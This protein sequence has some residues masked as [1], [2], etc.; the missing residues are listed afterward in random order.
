M[1]N[2]S[3]IQLAQDTNVI[4]RYGNNTGSFNFYMAHGGTNF[5]FWQGANAE[6]DGRYEPHIT[7]YDYDGPI[8]ESG[9]T[10]QPGIGIGDGCKFT[11]LREVIEQ[12]TGIEAPEVPPEPKI[13]GYGDVELEAVGTLMDAAGAP[14]VSDLPLHMEEYGQQRGI[15]VYRTELDIA[16][17]ISDDDVDFEKK[18]G[19]EEFLA[20]SSSSSPPTMNFVVPPSDYASVLI[21]GELQGRLV[22]GGAA[23]LTLPALDKEK[24]SKL[25]PRLGSGGSSSLTLDVVVEAMGRRNF[26]CDPPLGAWDTKGLQSTD[27]RIN[28]KLAWFFFYSFLFLLFPFVSHLSGPVYVGGSFGSIASVFF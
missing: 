24:L 17:Y 18:A 10:C 27:V 3:S 4:L 2:T 28:G 9:Q 6:T 20:S 25:S 13:L 15:I 11:L 26:G 19:K 14:I 23:N 5:G 1:A 7:S 22:R 21:D 16:E 8:S 12:Y